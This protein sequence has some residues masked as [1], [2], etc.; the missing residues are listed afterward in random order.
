MDSFD[1]KRFL[2]PTDGAVLTAIDIVSSKLTA[3]NAMPAF[4]YAW[5]DDKLEDC[6]SNIAKLVSRKLKHHGWPIVRKTVT[7]THCKGVGTVTGDCWWC[8]GTGKTD[9]DINTHKALPKGTRCMQCN[10]TGKETDPCHVCDSKKQL[11]RWV[12]DSSVK[13]VATEGW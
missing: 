7:C 9:Q 11:D 3:R 12:L 2:N 4:L 5:C 10:G 8:D 13:P 6:E 1:A